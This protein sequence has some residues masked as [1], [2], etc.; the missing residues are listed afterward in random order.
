M[1]FIYLRKLDIVLNK[2][3]VNSLRFMKIYLIYRFYINYK[4][5]FNILL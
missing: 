5:L 2:Y 4:D 3:L 1:I